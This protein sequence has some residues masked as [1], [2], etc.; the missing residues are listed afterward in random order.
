[1][2]DWN[3]N[4]SMQ[5]MYMFETSQQIEMLET[6]ILENEKTNGF[7]MSTINEIFRIMHTIKG[8]SAMML[9][10]NIATLAHHIEDLFYLIRSENRISVDYALMSDL[11]L[12]CIDFIKV[13]LEKIRNGD[14]LDGDSSVLVEQIKEFQ[15]GSMKEPEAAS[16]YQATIFYEDGCEM[17]NVRAITLIRN[18]KEVCQEVS[19]VPE[20]LGDHELS[21]Q[22]IRAEGLRLFFSTERTYEEIFDVFMKASFVQDFELKEH[23]LP[24][25]SIV[26]ASENKELG[27]KPSEESNLSSQQS[28]LSVHVSKLDQLMD[29]VGEMVIAEA[30]V[31]QNPDILGLE[32]E[33]FQKAAR[34][35]HK[36]TGELQDMVMSIRMVPIG[37][38]FQKMQRIVRDM[39]KKLDKE[40]QLSIVGEE[41]EVDKNIIENISDPLM[42]LVRN[43]MDHGIE[44]GEERTAKGKTS[45]GNLTLEAKTAGSEV[46][47]VVRDDGK[48]LNKAHILQKGMEKGLV[49]KPESEMSDKEIY[50]L[51]FLPGFSTQENITEFSGRGVG[52]DVVTRNLTAIRGSIS[53]ESAEGVGTAITLKIPLTLAIIDGMNIKVGSSCYTL[54]TVAIREF[55]RPAEQDII[56]D[57]EGNEMIIVRGRCL[58]ILRLHHQFNVDTSIKMMSEGILIILEEDER[59]MCVF[60][61]SL[62][63]QQQVVVKALPDYI[64]STRNINGLAGCTLLGNGSISLILD[65]GGLMDGSKA[66]EIIQA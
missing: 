66:E 13:E 56:I 9:Y 19:H 8:S 3:T 47:I 46:Q 32:L 28:M 33:S 61:D 35:L 11:L 41:T 43:A 15:A 49:H 52:M 54:P 44:S 60:A 53:V 64:K 6:I 37:S 14:S 21:V 25:D 63:G 30:M 48:G 59:A 57:P 62:L 29:L 65:V 36:I 55:F 26:E 24:A 50:N 34:L 22:L 17:E 12:D 39:S 40:I 23:K 5:E 42:H 10:E 51:I 31:T 27:G 18:L 16:H 2:S 1:M 4:E 45:I 7:A 38:T 58:P 20:D